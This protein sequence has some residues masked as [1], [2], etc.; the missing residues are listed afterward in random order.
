MF[1]LFKIRH[2]NGELI[3]RSSVFPLIPVSFHQN[4]TKWYPL[5]LRSSLLWIATPTG[6]SKLLRVTDQYWLQ[7]ALTNEFSS[8]FKF[9]NPN[10]WLSVGTKVWTPNMCRSPGKKYSIPNMVHILNLVGDWEILVN[11]LQVLGS[12]YPN[13]VNTGQNLLTFLSR[14][15][16]MY[17]T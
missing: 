13:P 4:L 17:S 5:K 6:H 10:F 7:W 16:V 1:P 2:L 9:Q 15:R 14:G 3:S 11:W 12:K 8:C